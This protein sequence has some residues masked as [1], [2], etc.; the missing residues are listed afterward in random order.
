MT[1]DD[2][3]LGA[4]N[5]EVAENQGDRWTFTAVNPDS[6]FVVAAHSGTRTQ[7]EAEVFVQKI[8][9][10]SDGNAPLFVSDSWF[11]QSVLTSIY[12]VL[13]VAN[14]KGRGRYP[15]P[16]KIPAPDLQY[17]QVHK[18]RNEK[19]RIVKISTRIVLGDEVEILNKLYD[20]K[21]CKTINT[22]YVESRNGNYRKDNARL[23]RKTL[24][25]SKQA[26]YHDA[27]IL[28]LTQIFN[29]THCVEGL[30]VEINPDAPKFKNKY[31]HRT[32]AMAERIIDKP[33]SVKELLFRRPMI[34]FP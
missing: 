9:T 10:R 20:A 16:K 18:E 34:I 19:G 6:S 21:R 24:C 29:Y 32:P 2:I 17:A 5:P 8:K 12:C 15:K 22:D 3:A 25:H 33:L 26:Q 11:Y 7:E 4:L 27:S 1:P 14:Y 31:Q 28:L 23:I 13:S 30:R